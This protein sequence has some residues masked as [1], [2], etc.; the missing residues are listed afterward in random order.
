M[1]PPGS[2]ASLA[3]GFSVIDDDVWS[4]LLVLL[5]SGPAHAFAG[6]FDSMGVMNEAVQDGG[7]RTERSWRGTL[8]F[9]P[10]LDLSLVLGGPDETI[11]LALVCDLTGRAGR[12]SD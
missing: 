7:I 10:C 8:V 9:L 6:E 2:R 1:M 4:S 3:D 5:S 11:V 12:E